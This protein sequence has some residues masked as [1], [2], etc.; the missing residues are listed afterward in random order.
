MAFFRTRNRVLD[1]HLHSLVAQGNHAAFLQLKYR[2]EKYS[3]II[4]KQFYEKNLDSGVSSP[5]LFSVC[6]SCFKSVLVKYD[7]QG[8]CFYDFW[9]KVTEQA[10]TDY[11][12]VNSYK[13]KA[14]TF[15]GIIS[16]DYEE[17]EKKLNLELIR[18][19]DEDYIKEKFRREIIKLIDTHKD[20]FNKK[21]FLILHYTLEGYSIKELEHGEIM[22][23]SSLYAT[24]NSASRKLEELIKQVKK[25]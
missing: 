12:L 25:K 18:E 5:D 1:L 6:M 7:P 16:L 22:S 9:K 10:L 19:N 11:L 24:S 17:E 14:K 4:C 15:D 13:A 3:R 2:Y 21:E 20:S 23:R 8:K